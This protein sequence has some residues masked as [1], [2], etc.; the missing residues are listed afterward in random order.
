MSQT[1]NLSLVKQKVLGETDSKEEAS[2]SLTIASFENGSF[3]PSKV[4]MGK[5]YYLGVRNEDKKNLM[6]LSSSESS[7]NT[8]R[9]YGFGE[10]QVVL[11]PK[12]GTYQLIEKN[13]GSKL[14]IVVRPN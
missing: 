3:H 2:K 6:W 11:M 1:L 14:T 4:W 12:E 9:G 7:L 13:S 8:V 5:G 10:Q